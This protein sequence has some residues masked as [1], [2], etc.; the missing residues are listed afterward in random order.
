MSNIFNKNRLNL[1]IFS[2]SASLGGAEQALL[3]LCKEFIFDYK[4]INC[5]VILPTNGK[6]K[7]KLEKIGIKTLVADYFWWC[8]PQELMDNEKKFRIDYSFKNIEN[9]IKSCLENHNIDVIMTNTLVIPWGSVASFYLNKPHV[10][11]I[12]E[13]GKLDHNFKFFFPF[14]DIIKYIK[15]GADLIL[16][17]SECVKK[18]LF[19]GNEENKI[20]TVRQYIE[21]PKNLENQHY[22]VKKKEFFEIGIFGK[23]TE[24][25]GQKDAILAISEIIKERKDVRLVIMG[26][27]DEVYSKKLEEI[28]IEYNL[29][30]H[31]TIYDFKEDPFPIIKNMD[32]VLVCSKFEA[33]GRTTIE[34]MLCKK[35]V[36]GTNR[37]GTI[38]L[39]KEGY[40][41]LLY[42]PGDYIGLSEKIKFF[43]NNKNK[44]KEFGENG[45]KF[46]KENF[47][48]EKYGGEISKLIFNLKNKNIEN[49]LQREELIKKYFKN[50]I[51]INN[52]KKEIKKRKKILIIRLDHI[53]D[54]ILSLPAIKLLKKKYENSFIT[55]LVG[56][57][58]KPIAERV[59]EI[60]EVLTFN[61]FFEEAEKG[62]I[63][64]G[65]SDLKD[66]ENNLKKRE[67]DLAIDLRRQPETREILKLSG[68]KV[69]IGFSTGKEDSWL[70]VRMKPNSE[71][72]DLPG[73]KIKIHQTTQMIKL[74]G[75]IEGEN[76]KEENIKIEMPEIEI[77]KGS[78]KIK[79]Y[80]KLFKDEFIIG[81]HPGAG[82]LIKQWPLEYFSYLAELFIEKTNSKIVILG[83]NK[84]ER[85]AL[86]IIN[87]TKNKERITSLAGKFNLIE[88][89]NFLKYCNLFIGNDSGASHLAGIMGVPTLTIFSGQVSPFEWHPLG[90][91]TLSIAVNVPCAPCYKISPQ[92][93]PFSLKCLKLLWPEKVWEAAQ[94]LITLSGIT[95]P[96][97]K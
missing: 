6:L 27:K 43:M 79:D 32:I 54:F 40:N 81:I 58:N 89:M 62:K 29:K 7:E 92:Q 90:E 57:W 51:G 4:N 33:F 83:G 25:K 3:E 73:K 86:E 55:V 94:E 72:D 49:K 2:H 9:I 50:N 78:E 18:I 30:D 44:I 59:R 36:I 82:N 61:F 64:I 11:F 23:I 52:Y 42:E 95:I 8:D 93:C 26:E 39:I 70:T 68:A 1:C 17:N 96:F 63:L 53:G 48:K 71:M 85:F 16:T 37:G 76:Q 65:K 21:I 87:K 91:K 46:V 35:P 34:A 5:L 56:S 10:W 38:E 13:F 84:D 24:T 12:H 15:N 14:D 67:F 45:Y 60:D 20:I 80:L 66:L 77:K 69:K 47:T 19:N 41:G 22:E 28:I 31:I 75:S 74:I 97:K 88:F